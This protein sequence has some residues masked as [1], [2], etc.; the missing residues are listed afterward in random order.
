MTYLPAYKYKKNATR[1]TMGAGAAEGAVDASDAGAIEG[2]RLVV[3]GAI[4]MTPCPVPRGRL[5]LRGAW[6]QCAPW[7]R[8]CVGQKKTLLP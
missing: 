2:A 4:R 6:N 7:L 3:R 1:I 8:P 5:R